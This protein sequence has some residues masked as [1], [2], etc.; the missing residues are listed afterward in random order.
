MGNVLK[1]VARAGR[2]AGESRD[3]D[4]HKAMNYLRLAL[5]NE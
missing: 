4:L 3:S 2:K 5:E 1:Y